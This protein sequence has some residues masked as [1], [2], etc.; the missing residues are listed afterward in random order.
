MAISRQELK[1][2]QFVSTLDSWYEFYLNYQKQILYGAIIV[3]VALA[4]AYGAVAWYRGRQ[5]KA[6]KLL[7]AGLEAYHAPLVEGKEAPPPGITVYASVA[8]RAQAAGQLFRQDTESYGST[9]AGRMARYYLALTELDQNHVAQAVQQLQ[10]L[11][12]GNHAEV[13]GLAGNALANLQAGQGKTAQAEA[14]LRQLMAR[15][16]SLVPKTLVML[17]LAELEATTDPA[18]ARRLYQ[19]VQQA[20][21]NSQTAQLAQQRLAEL[22]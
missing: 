13:A 1:T 3:A 16:T 21:P 20:D 14:T 18:A 2:D 17:E 12:A 15:P 6:Q 11:A 4:V 19:Q 5:A 9:A 22:P 7:A 10:A 8:A